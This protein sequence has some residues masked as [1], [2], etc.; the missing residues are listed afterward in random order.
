[1][2]P[3]LCD[4]LILH[5]AALRP[6]EGALSS[7]IVFKWDRKALEG[8]PTSPPQRA[9]LPPVSSEISVLCCSHVR[10]SVGTPHFHGISIFP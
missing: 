4:M 5:V 9:G 1:M 2:I 7:D 6:S 8:V 10:L 3:G